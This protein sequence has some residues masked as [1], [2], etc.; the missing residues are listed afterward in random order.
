M[1][2]AISARIL[3]LGHSSLPARSFLLRRA[4]T[5][6]L[7]SSRASSIAF[8]LSSSAI[9]AAALVGGP[10]G[11]VA[12]ASGDWLGV[13]S[14]YHSARGSVS[15]PAGVDRRGQGIHW[16]AGALEPDAGAPSDAAEAPRADSL[17]SGMGPTFGVSTTRNCASIIFSS[18]TLTF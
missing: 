7:I 11:S 15:L 8:L 4:I 2:F 6:S 3:A 17:S 12:K 13:S 5:L 9:W 14:S 1:I 16:R 10:A 18:K